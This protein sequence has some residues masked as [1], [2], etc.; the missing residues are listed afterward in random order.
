MLVSETRPDSGWRAGLVLGPG[1]V[2]CLLA[3]IGFRPLPQDLA[4][5]E[6]ADQRALYRVPHF[7]NVVSNLPFAVIG[8]LGCW[9]VVGHGRSSPAFEEP[10]E[11]VAYLVF[12]AGEF[13]TCFGSGYYHSGPSNE[14]LLWDRLV[15]SLVLTSMFAIVVTEFVDRRVG[16]FM[17][18]PIV[19]LGVVSVSIG[20]TPRCTVGATC[21]ST[22]SCSFIRLSRCPS[23]FCCAGHATRARDF[24]R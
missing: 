24:L 17:L 9:W 20:R 4:Y 15:F 11:R 23:S 6:F 5:H 13:L 18:A 12:F 16:R 7:W 19:S 3:L 10:H 14:T 1:L 8:V 22:R 2:I 21:A